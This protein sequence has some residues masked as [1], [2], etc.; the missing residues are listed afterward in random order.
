PRGTSLNNFQFR[1][2]DGRGEVELIEEPGPR[3]GYRAWIRV[4]D[5]KGGGE[6]YKMEMSWTNLWT[7][8]PSRGGFGQPR[9]R[10][11]GRGGFGNEAF[12]GVCFYEKTDY[13]GDEFCTE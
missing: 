1:G 13:E 12:N 7:N 5:T 2:I 9:G 6:D 11:R 10:G 3:N 8:Q 4:R